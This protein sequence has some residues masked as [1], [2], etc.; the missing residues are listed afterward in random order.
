MDF[1]AERRSCA[2]ALLVVQAILSLFS[3]TVASRACAQTLLPAF[4]PVPPLS[5]SDLPPSDLPPANPLDEEAAESVESEELA[6]TGMRLEEL[7]SLAIGNHPQLLGAYAAVRSAEGRAFQAGLYPNPQFGVS[8]PQLAGSESQYNAFISQDILTG[9]KLRLDT[10]A[11]CQEVERLRLELRRERF[12]VLTSVRRRFYAVLTAQNR[13]AV[14]EDLVRMAEKSQD[15]GQRLQ[16]AGLGARTDTLLLEIESHKAQVALVNARTNLD[17]SRRQLA[18]EVG[19][20]ELPIDRLYGDLSAELPQFEL[21]ELQQ[22]VVTLNSQTAAAEAASRRSRVLLDRAIVEPSPTF[23]VMGGYQR[24]LQGVKDQGIVQVLVSVPLWDKNEGNIR[25]AQA[26]VGRAEAEVRRVQIELAQQAA[27]ALAQ[28]QSAVNLVQKYQQE[29]LPK[30]RESVEL[31]QRLYEQEQIDFL[32]L[33][34]AQRT[35]GEVN[36]DYIDAQANRWSA[37]VTI[38]NLLQVEQFP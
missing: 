34:Q 32:R 26:D 12:D 4:A 25:A 6:P 14:L 16:Q 19:L 27:E 33:L 37:A 15:L 28:Y 35:L 5:P 30:S 24:Q 31:T 13:V 21:I 7:E 3:P 1:S 23:N 2:F 10:A 8:S 18:A 36:L 29:I 38:A 11:A 22:D 9:G 17:A 20:P